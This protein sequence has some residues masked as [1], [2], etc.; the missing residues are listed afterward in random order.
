MKV[1]IVGGVAGGATAAAR[2]RKIGRKGGCLKNRLL[3]GLLAAAGDY[4]M[5]AVN[6]LHMEPHLA[7]PRGLGGKPVVL[8]VVPTHIYGHA[9]AAIKHKKGDSFIFSGF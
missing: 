4:N 7:A 9:R 3:V 8:R 5:A 2:L 6:I 1:I